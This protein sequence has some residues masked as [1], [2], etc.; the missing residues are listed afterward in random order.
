[1]LALISASTSS[2]SIDMATARKKDQE[3]TTEFFH[4]PEVDGWFLGLDR[5]HVLYS[6]LYT[7]A[8][9][10]NDARAW[11]PGLVVSRADKIFISALFADSNVRNTIFS[12]RDASELRN[13]AMG[14]KGSNIGVISS[15]FQVKVTLASEQ[16]AFLVQI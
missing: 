2:N 14:V 5:H 9:F 12:T 4:K 8:S 3:K 7:T 1:M 6:P 13:Q 11:G 16:T 15:L 10:T